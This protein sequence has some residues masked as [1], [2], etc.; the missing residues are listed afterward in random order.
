MEDLDPEIIPPRREDSRAMAPL[1]TLVVETGLTPSSQQPALWTPDSVPAYRLNAMEKMLFDASM[2]L[3][4]SVDEYAMGLT[5]VASAVCRAVPFIPDGALQPSYERLLDKMVR[6]GKYS[7]LPNA[8]DF[9][10]A[11]QELLDEAMVRREKQHKLKD[12]EMRR[13]LRGKVGTGIVK[14]ISEWAREAAEAGE[15]PLPIQEGDT[16]DDQT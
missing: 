16:Y 6:A 15:R 7:R 2:V 8:M 9:A 11:Y 14:H 4:A 5:E 13:R 3:G 1:R 12:A 10:Q